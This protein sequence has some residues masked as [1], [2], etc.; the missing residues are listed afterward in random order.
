[1]KRHR[2]LRWFIRTINAFGCSGLSWELVGYLLRKEALER[3]AHHV[4]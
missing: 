4:D 3:E 2:L 1:M